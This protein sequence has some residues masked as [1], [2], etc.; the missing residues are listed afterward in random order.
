MA[1]KNVL[2]T[3]S[4]VETSYT[5]ESLHSGVKKQY[6]SVILYTAMGHHRFLQIV[7]AFHK[8]MTETSILLVPL[9]TCN[10][11]D[12]SRSNPKDCFRWVSV[13]VCVCVAIPFPSLV[14]AHYASDFSRAPYIWFL[15]ELVGSFAGMASQI[16]SQ[17]RIK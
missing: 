12:K 17:W 8:P 14:C 11:S 3:R 9:A 2:V 6:C 1:C 13:T 7:K 5:T 16:P 10:Y 15:S 4:S